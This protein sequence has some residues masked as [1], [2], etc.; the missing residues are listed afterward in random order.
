[1]LF[2]ARVIR[3]A[4]LA[5]YRIRRQGY[6]VARIDRRRKIPVTSLM[7]ALGSTARPS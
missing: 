6:R 3:I 5:R 1:M 2:A 4:A 7:F